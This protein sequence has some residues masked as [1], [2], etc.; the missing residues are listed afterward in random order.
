VCTCSSV[1]LQQ[2]GAT[3]LQ[4]AA[5]LLKI[6]EGESLR[7]ALMQG[8]CLCRPAEDGSTATHGPAV[9]DAFARQVGSGCL[10]G[11]GRLVARCAVVKS[12]AA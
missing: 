1:H 5:A 4:V 7:G 6:C 12:R 3:Y 9:Q 11:S 8:G 2:K 10:V